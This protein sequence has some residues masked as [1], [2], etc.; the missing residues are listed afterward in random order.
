MLVAQW[1]YSQEIYQPLI[2]RYNSV[3]YIFEG[4][5]IQSHPYLTADG[6][7]IYTSNVIQIFKVF[8]GNISCGTIE[9][10]TDGGMVGDLSMTGSHSLMPVVGDIGIFLTSATTKELPA[11]SVYTF[12]N[13]DK[14]DATYDW[15]SFI[16]YQFDNSNW[17]AYDL[18]QT[19]SDLNTL[20]NLTDQI[21]GLQYIDCGAQLPTPPQPIPAAYHPDAMPIYSHAEFNRQKD[22]MEYAKIHSNRPKS[23]RSTQT[24]DY[25][26]SN[27][28]ITGINPQYFEFDIN[29]SDA[30]AGGSRYFTWA[31]ARLVYD[32]AVFGDSIAIHGRIDVTNGTLADTNCYFVINPNDESY[33]SVDIPI[34]SHDY[35]YCKSQITTNPQQVAHVKM[36]MLG[37][38][39][40]SRVSIIDTLDFFGS[41]V[42][43][44]LSAYS[45]ASNDSMQTLYDAVSTSS[46]TIPTCHATINSFDPLIVNA[47]VRDIL[48]IHG[49]QFGA[50]RGIGNLYFYKADDAN[51]GMSLALEDSDYILW[52]DTLVKIYVPS[53]EDSLSG[54]AVG[55]GKFRIVTSAMQ[56]DTTADSLNVYYALTNLWLPNHHKFFDYLYNKSGSGGYQFFVDTSVSHHPHIYD[57]VKT[58]LHDWVCATGVNFAIL[59]DTFGLADTA[60]IDNTNLIT[61]G[62]LPSSIGAK[63]TRI[64]G[65]CS[66]INVGKVKEIDLVISDDPSITWF[67]DTS[68]HRA[69]PYGELDLYAVLLH[70]FGHAVGHRHVIDPS[71]IMYYKTP[72]VPTSGLPAYQRGVV[73]T[74][75]NSAVDGGL[76]EVD[77]SRHSSTLIGCPNSPNMIILTTT[78]CRVF[79]GIEDVVASGSIKVYPN[80]FDKK[81]S[82]QSELPIVS[83]SIS[84]IVGIEI[85]HW[86]IN[87]QKGAMIDIT[88]N[89]AS[90]IY[91]I[92]IKSDWSTD[93]IKL[94]HD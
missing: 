89:I 35:G 37:C 75:D 73:L 90:G 47:G 7:T 24:L 5:V 32:P 27:P 49:I 10:I 52:S 19:F 3:D 76:R 81:I 71:A 16:H 83:I 48:N 40:G 25:T 15:Q 22:K 63:C 6:L 9:M 91:F 60:R 44:S 70:E 42:M 12:T 14:V 92:T 58:A 88:Q 17:N 85:N 86:D 4:Q 56:S 65:S 54:S 62:P 33:Y 26:M 80:P 59:R 93:I 2:D 11:Q 21:T 34:A 30:N 23:S 77:S 29:L 41:A 13:T 39:G 1:G 84:N 66:N 18:W 46:T 74:A 20:Y 72:N 45:N 82:I 38:G 57:C 67:T 53:V 64:S 28:H 8:K 87:R 55:T 50:S 36:R 79:S 94:S 69:V 61:M 31:Y 43:V 51:S 68:G 78:G